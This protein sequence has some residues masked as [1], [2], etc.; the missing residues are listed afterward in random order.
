M[1]TL[2][3]SRILDILLED[4]G[5]LWEKHWNTR[6]NWRIWR[7]QRCLIGNKLVDAS[8]RCKSILLVDD[9]FLK[10]LQNGGRM[11]LL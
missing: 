10:F 9:F 6:E 8:E 4:M 3:N 5:K 11:E 7:V 1:K 2:E